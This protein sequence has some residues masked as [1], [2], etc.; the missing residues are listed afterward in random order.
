MKYLSKDHFGPFVICMEKYNEETIMKILEAGGFSRLVLS[1]ASGDPGWPEDRVRIQVLNMK[2]VRT[3]GE[4]EDLSGSDYIVHNRDY[5]NS[6][7]GKV[8]SI[9]DDSL[10]FKFMNGGLRIS[11]SGEFGIGIEKLAK[12]IA[13]DE[14]SGF[15]WEM[16]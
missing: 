10:S 5:I 15:F 7:S 9:A 4:E 6:V 1:G 13:E 16:S 3:S 12:E 8:I 2:D 14:G 11:L